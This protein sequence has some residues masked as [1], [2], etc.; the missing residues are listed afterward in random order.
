MKEALKEGRATPKVSDR[1]LD[2]YKILKCGGSPREGKY[3]VWNSNYL[4]VC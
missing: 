2:E 1:T 4:W 3:Y